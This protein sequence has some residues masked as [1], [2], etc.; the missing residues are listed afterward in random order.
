MRRKVPQLIVVHVVVLLW[1][2]ISGFAWGFVAEAWTAPQLHRRNVVGRHT[3]SSSCSVWTSRNSIRTTTSNRAAVKDEEEANHHG[4]SRFPPSSRQRRAFLHGV[5]GIVAASSSQQMLCAAAAPAHAQ[6][7]RAV[8][9]G[10]LAC[11]EQGNCLQ[12][13]ELDGALG[14]TWGGKERCDPTDPMCS[15]SGKLLEQPL[16][17]KSVPQLPPTVLVTHVAAIQIEI[18]RGEVGVL[19]LGLYGNELPEL[20][21]QLVDFLSENGFTTASNSAAAQNS[22]IGA[23]QTPV[24]LATGGALTGIVPA[25]TIELGV[26]S[27]AYAYARSRGR[28]KAG[29]DF[30]PQPRPKPLDVNT[31]PVVRLHDC[32]GL[33]S[34]PALGLGY[35][36]TGFE[37]DDEAFESAVVVTD[38]D[39]PA[40]DKST[41]NS[42]RIV[43]G[44]IL[45]S[46]SMAFLERLANLPTKR[47]IRGVIPGQTSGPPLPKVVVRQVQVSKVTAPLQ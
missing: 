14:W 41:K 40:L 45:D 31:I 33:V 13:G 32:A 8:G 37:S 26:P 34:V 17:G 3:S 44:Q 46:T 11:R 39:V 10:E 36:G 21:Q 29:D 24:S 16:V 30:V 9:T 12:V 4:D 38:T 28:A 25:T 2:T 23:I 22:M 1:L 7:T 5:V 47:G 42:K 15:G 6:V 20:V 43:V 18:G 19:K 27:Q 35:G